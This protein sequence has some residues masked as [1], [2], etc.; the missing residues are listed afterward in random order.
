MVSIFLNLILFVFSV[1]NTSDFSIVYN[2]IGIEQSDDVYKEI[3]NK[4]YDLRYIKNLTWNKNINFYI[5]DFDRLNLKRNINTLPFFSHIFLPYGGFSLTKSFDL[6][7][8]Y[9]IDNFGESGLKFNLATSFGQATLFWQHINLVYPLKVTNDRLKMVYTFSF[10]TSTPQYNSAL[11]YESD[12]NT[13]YNAF[14]KTWK[15]LNVDFNKTNENGFI[16]NQGI[17]Y[18][19]PLLEVNSITI[20]DYT[21][22]IL[23]AISTDMT[24]KITPMW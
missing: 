4:R 20:W 2:Y 8:F 18:R 24:T 11:Y 14:N 23:V 6:G 19:I 13:F 7:F 5:E 17:D 9:A 1:D 3:V 10:F 21:T 15:I 22:N 12:V 16:L